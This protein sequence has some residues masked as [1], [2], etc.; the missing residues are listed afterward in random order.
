MS[1]LETIVEDLKTLPSDKVEDAAWFVHTLVMDSAKARAITL[2]RTAMALSTEDV[3]EMG[4]AIAETC[5]AVD[6]H[7]W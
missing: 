4:K 7:V 3:D 6:N 5:E 2:Q 1:A